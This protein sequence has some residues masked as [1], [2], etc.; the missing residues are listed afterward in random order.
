LIV[1]VLVALAVR[2]AASSGGAGG[3]SV[4]AG[5]A[6]PPG[7]FTE[8][9]VLASTAPRSLTGDQH[10][11]EDAAIARTLSYTPYVR[12]AGSQHRELA[13]TFDDGPGPYTPQILSI[14][15]RHGVPATFFE[16]GILER[17]FHAST[18]E[19]V[20]DDFPIGDHTF[21]HLAMSRLSRRDQQ[22]QLLA[23]VAATGAWGAPFP[24]L[25]RPPYGLWNATTLSLLHKYRMLMVLWTVD[26]ADWRRPGV[27]AIVRAAVGGA[28]PGAIILMHDAG[29]NR[30][31][32]L[33]ALPQIIAQLRARGYK[34]VTV[35]RLLLD[36]PA[37]ANQRIAAVIGAGG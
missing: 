24:R 25:F 8:I 18:A 7:F 21:G 31:Q 22:A 36:N 26:T 34:L 9:R 14:L 19:I 35:P 37:P 5:A 2:L 27:R 28:R 15:E 32:T 33:A 12:I 23:D 29:G 30:A 3:G 16:I 10:A 17:Y 4:H 20:A 11:D 1:L 13:L 6:P